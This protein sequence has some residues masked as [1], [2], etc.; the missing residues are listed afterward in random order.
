MTWPREITKALLIL[1]VFLMI[2]FIIHTLPTTSQGIVSTFA[3]LSII[4]Y[5]AVQVWHGK[6]VHALTLAILMLLALNIVVHCYMWIKEMPQLEQ[7][8]IDQE[9]ASFLEEI[10]I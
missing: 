10:I 9:V 3:S 8:N 7:A 2:R 5:F 6:K 4:I 1:V